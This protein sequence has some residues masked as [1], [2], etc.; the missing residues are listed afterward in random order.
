MK[1]GERKIQKFKLT[2]GCVVRMKV[3]TGHKLANKAAFSNLFTAKHQH[4]VDKQISQI[5][6]K[7]LTVI[8]GSHVEELYFIIDVKVVGKMNVQAWIYLQHKKAHL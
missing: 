6:I 7:I 1:S 3:F 8:D 2:N 5:S 4:S